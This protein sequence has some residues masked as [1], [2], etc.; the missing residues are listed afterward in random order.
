MTATPPDA[1]GSTDLHAAFV[2]RRI[3]IDQA[4]AALGVTPRAIYQQIT[5]RNIPFIKMFG[6]RYIDPDDL[7]AAVVQVHNA[8]ARG[9]GRPRNA[10]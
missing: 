8:P 6:T 4:A 10:A 1:A 2:G 7:R 9:R 3:T 5:L